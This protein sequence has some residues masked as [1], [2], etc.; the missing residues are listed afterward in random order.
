MGSA[1]DS[2]MTLSGAGVVK[3]GALAL[4]LAAVLGVS[5]TCGCPVIDVAGSV[6]QAGSCTDSETWEMPSSD[7]VSVRG[8]G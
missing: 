1:S 8:E 6:S 4:V 7:R 2:V 3:V 5:G